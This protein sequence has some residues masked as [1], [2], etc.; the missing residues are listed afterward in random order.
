MAALACEA[1]EHQ[2]RAMRIVNPTPLTLC[3]PPPP[4]FAEINEPPSPS[5][6]PAAPSYFDQASPT[7]SSPALRQLLPLP[8]KT[9][10]SQAK[11][12]RRSKG[13]PTKA[14]QES[15][16]IQ[17]QNIGKKHPDAFVLHQLSQGV[18]VQIL[19]EL[20]EPPTVPTPSV[21][22]G[23]SIKYFYNIPKKQTANGAAIV[24]SP[25]L[26]PCAERY[27]LHNP[28]GWLCVATLTLPRWPSIL[29]VSAYV[30]PD[31]R[32]EI[33]A[34]LPPIL[35]SQPHFFLEGDFNAVSCPHF[36][37]SLTDDPPWH[38]LRQPTTSSPPSLVDTFRTVNPTSLAFTRYKT[39][40]RRPQKQIDLLLECAVMAD[41]V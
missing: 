29:L 7:P 41:G 11:G 9:A 34:L 31:K 13:L 39:S 16:H 4:S 8:P 40:H 26:P 38:W 14:L 10:P 36:D 5:T 37:L 25:A 30:P 1:N 3:L 15:L 28:K 20:N 35:K 24:F 18:G 19:Q 12:Y 22:G 2:P 27:V 6:A 23:Y 33:E 32:P 21:F 17:R